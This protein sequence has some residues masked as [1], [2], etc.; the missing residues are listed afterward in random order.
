M[1]LDKNPILY[2]IILRKVVGRE[3]NKETIAR[4][5]QHLRSL[6]QDGRLILCGPFS[7]HP[8]G[9]VVLKAKDK[10]EATSIANQDPFV[11]EGFRTFEVR[12]WQIAHK[13]NNYLG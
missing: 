12:T 9:A 8:S 7:D 2:V 6:D 4:H 3:L 1:E 13:E 11:K 5:V 10:A